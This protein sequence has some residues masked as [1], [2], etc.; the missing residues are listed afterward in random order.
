MSAAI[1]NG[2][3]HQEG[4]FGGKENANIRSHTNIIEQDTSHIHKIKR[5]DICKT[6]RNNFV[7]EPMHADDEVKSPSD[8]NK[9]LLRPSFLDDESDEEELLTELDAELQLRSSP[10]RQLQDNHISSQSLIN[11]LR[12]KTPQID[13]N[14]LK[15]LEL[16]LFQL[17]NVI[18]QRE[19]DINNT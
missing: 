9:H 8:I 6:V 14:V 17:Q 18:L 15:K 7:C 5:E 4:A 13:V 19:K 11:G 12:E 10:L 16:Q 2:N 1:L 3:L